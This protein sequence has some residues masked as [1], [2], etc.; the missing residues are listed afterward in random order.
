MS[1][2][3]PPT[4]RPWRGARDSAHAWMLVGVALLAAGVRGHR[5][6]A[7]AW[8]GSRTPPW[9][10]ASRCARCIRPTTSWSW[11]STKRRSTRS[12]RTGPSRA[13]STRVRSKSCAPT[14]P[15]DRLRRA[16][17]A[18]HRRTPRP[19]PVWAVDRAGNVVLATTETGSRARGACSGVMRQP[20]PRQR[21]RGRRRLQR[22][23]Q[24]RDPAVPVFGRRA[25]LGCRGDR[26]SRH[27]APAPQLLVP[28]RVRLDRLPGTGGNGPERVLRGPHPRPRAALRAG[29]EDRRR[30]RHQR[31]CCRTSTPPR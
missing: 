3:R 1:A 2:A 18:T 27:R 28:G 14:C 15:H 13:P 7:G 19:G 12:T 20:R 29:R 21:G 10:P 4:N 6:A 30:G 22:Q 8:N 9:T 23:L 17:H 5:A 25:G 31:R 11:G 26:R 16:V 24:R